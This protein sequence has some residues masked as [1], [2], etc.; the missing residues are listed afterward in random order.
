MEK[1]AELISILIE[2]SQ[3][4]MDFWNFQIIISLAMLGFLFSNPTAM[5]QRQIRLFV[6]LT[7]IGI[8]VFSIFSLS[9]HQQREELLWRALDARVGAEVTSYIPE[10]IAYVEALQP[11]AFPIK[12]GALAVAD[13]IVVAAIWVVPTLKSKTQPMSEQDSLA[14]HT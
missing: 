11:T 10:E 5:A 12:A 14:D 13:L 8:A 9:V 3:R 2:H 4:F 7:F 6:S 1:Y